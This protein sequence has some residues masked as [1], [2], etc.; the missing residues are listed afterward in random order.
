LEA[1]RTALAGRPA[2]LVGGAVRDR[3]LGRT[4]VDLDVTLADADIKKAAR[5]LARAIGGTAFPLSEA[6]GAWRVIAPDHA[7]H[8]D[9]AAL[10]GGTIEEDLAK[11]DFT[12][13]AI[14]EPLG[15]GPPVDPYGGMEDIAARRLRMVSPEAFDDDPLRTMRLARIACELGIDPE[16][17]TAAAARA[18]AR[19]LEDVAPERIFAELKRIVTDD[20]V[21]AGMR[22]LHDLGLEEVVLPELTALRG[23]EQS[24]YHHLDVYDH[25]MAVLEEAVA[26]E[27]DPQAV[28][29]DER[30][31]AV[32]ELMRTPL[33][34]DLDRWQALRFAALLHDAAKPATRDVRPDGRVT[35]L[36]HDREGAELARRVLGRLRTSERLRAFV[37]GVVRHHLRLGFLVHERPLSRRAMYRYLRA[38]DPI[39]V[40]ASTFTVADR[41]ATR[42]R[43]AEAAIAAHVDL[44]C[45]VLDAA[46]PWE[47]DGAPTAPVRGNEL[48]QALGIKPGPDLGVLLDQ[49]A[50]AT[51]VGEVSGP[52]DAIAWARERLQVPGWKDAPPA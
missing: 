26:L 42:G 40:E 14:A 23:V 37:A 33:A 20:R 8:A 25:T 44:A 24:A 4:I 31:A 1:A 16:P 32:D 43:N 7:W 15:G 51:Y 47:R 3:E 11:R 17:D 35:F 46:L 48:A 34:D 19:K 28:F 2:W 49:L 45:E 30:G 10:R 39:P 5:A 29:G 38:C 27:C 9:L 52:D 41:K 12:I 6:F 21:L 18:R 13:N 22:L 36:G 50:E